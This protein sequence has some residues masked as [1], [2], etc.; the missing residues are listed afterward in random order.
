MSSNGVRFVGASACLGL[1]L[2]AAGVSAVQAQQ[3]N[4][5]ADT[6]ASD[7][8]APQ[9]VVVTGSRI[10]RDGFTAP[11]PVTVVNAERFEQRAMTNAGDALNELPSF[12]AFSTP[13]TQQLAGGNVGAR[14]LDL[15]GLGPVRTLVLVDGKR[16]VP[17][18]T[19]STIDTNLIPSVLIDRVEVVT[20]GASAAYGSDA[21][22]GVVNFIMNNKLNGLKV[23]SSY[24]SSTRG[25]D[26]MYSGSIAGGLPLWGD[27]GHFVAALEYEKDKGMGDCYTRSW[28]GQEWLNLG[29]LPAGLNGRPANNI[30]PNVHTA[31]VSQDGVINSG[32]AT[33]PLRGITFNHDGTTRPFQYGEIY[34][35]NLQPIFMK[36]GEGA[37][38]N[39]FIDGFRIKVPVERATLFTHTDLNFESGMHGGLDLSYGRVEGNV[40]SSQYRDSAGNVNTPNSF[41]AIKS[42]NPFIPASVQTLMTANSI[43]SFTL[44]RAFG[45]IGNAVAD[46]VNKT[47]RAVASLNGKMGGSWSW[48]GYYQ[49]GNNDFRQDSTNNVM[50]S[51]MVKAV[52]AVRNSSGQVVCAVNANASTADDDPACAPFNPFGRDNFSEAAKTYV[53]PPGFQTTKFTQNVLAANVQGDVFST[54][55]GPV[56]LAAGL[57]GRRDEISGDA[58]IISK[59]DGTATNPGNGFFV[60][61]GQALGGQIDVREGYVETNIPLASQAPFAR[62]LELNGAGRRTRYERSSPGLADTTLSVTTWK[63]GMVWEPFASVRF[64]ATRSRDIRAP[65]LAELFGP[66]LK[67]GSSLTDPI[68]GQANPT[69]I[70]GSNP[71]LVPEIADTKTF[72]VVLQ[73]TWSWLSNFKMS[74]DYYDITIDGAIGTLGAQTIVNRCF[75][76]AVEFC[77]LIDRDANQVVTT[78][79]DLQ[80][81]VNSV[82][83][84]GVDLEADYHTPLGERFGDLDFRV[85]T[86]YV[87]DLLTVD[88][89]GSTQRAGLTGWRAGTQPG[90]P[91][92]LLDTLTT[93]RMGPASVNLHNRYIPAGKYNTAF[94]GPDDPNYSITLP[95]SSNVNRV[96]DQFYTD[97]SGD[98]KIREGSDGSQVVLFAA[99]NNVFD[100]EPPL[101]P[102]GSGNGN[103]ILFDPVGRAYRLGVRVAF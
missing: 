22:A 4:G 70:S 82:I 91:E 55:A 59:G 36:G 14:I 40:L 67:A 96:H 18:T 81:N 31:T 62:T 3:N 56:S 27:R 15:R 13:A 101:A 32:S 63:A 78:V 21:V 65:N 86:T 61:N 79:R 30:E 1:G 49:Y 44:G 87:K 54:W 99:V 84:K 23:A 98:W 97:L 29:N 75:Q 100:A 69:L 33:F 53:T 17:S 92:W 48:D 28:C 60:L 45:D 76:G 85:L 80:L 5:A 41:G 90:L 57:E 12:R 51:R 52:D 50:I 94:T 72:G 10:A 8:S 93:W 35:T 39:A 103:F 20:G 71:A 19:Q 89:V 25:D 34:G 9:E 88:S 26:Q 58:D 46:S 83:T 66:R 16:F 42:G 37:G 24:G 102:S 74:V 73:P 47:F 38:E 43:P 77:P 7:A 68:K 95:T 2:I 6:T 64:R 11:T